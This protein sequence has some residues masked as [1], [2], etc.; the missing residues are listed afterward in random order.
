M[1]PVSVWFWVGFHVF[2]VAMLAIDLGVFQREKHKVSVKEGSIWT[3]VWIGLSLLFCLG[4]YFWQGQGPAL[5]FLTAYVIEKSLSVDNIFVF[6]V[7]FNYFSVPDEYQH[8]TLFW[9]VLGAMIMRA[10]FIV[11]GV[12]LLSTFH[13][14]IYIFGAFLVYT[15]VRLAF[16]GD[17]EVHPEENPVINAFRRFFPVTENYVEGKFFVR[18]NGALMATPLFLVLLMIESTDVLFA[19]DSVPA[20]LSI[21]QNIFIAYTSNI[22]AILGLRALYF[23]LAGVVDKFEYLHYGLAVVLTF[24]GVKM[25]TSGFFHIPTGV[26]LAVILGI[27]TISI[28]ASLLHNGRGGSEAKA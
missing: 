12:A 15:G 6:V 17:E 7:I 4:L 20:V 23:V 2:V 14:V 8:E 27:L 26:S 24:V 13:W 22:M 21:T 10:L 11:L 9:G 18:R 25:L 16:Q 5:Q 19:V 3:A 1:E 28:V